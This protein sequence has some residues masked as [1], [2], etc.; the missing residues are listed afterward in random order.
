MFVEAITWWLE[1]GSRPTSK[2]MATRTALLAAAM[3]KEASTW[4]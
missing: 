4:Q 1:Q 2:E 3:F